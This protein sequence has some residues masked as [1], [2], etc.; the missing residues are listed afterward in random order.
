MGW[1]PSQYLTLT[2]KK[3]KKR[4]E[5]DLK[6]HSQ[7]WPTISDFV[8][9]TCVNHTYFP[10]RKPSPENYGVH[11]PPPTPSP[12][13]LEILRPPFSSEFGVPLWG[14]MDTFWN[15]MSYEEHKIITFMKVKYPLPKVTLRNRPSFHMQ[16]TKDT[17]IC[18]PT[19]HS[20]SATTKWRTLSLLG[21][22]SSGPRAWKEN[23]KD[24]TEFPK[25]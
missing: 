22:H 4:W 23:A 18:K 7:N 8:H 25:N 6:L 19:S 20:S 14:G 11:L 9:A 5:Y 16:K 13:H 15:Y 3:M 24:V 1:S 12:S 21:G 2:I 10:L 17:C